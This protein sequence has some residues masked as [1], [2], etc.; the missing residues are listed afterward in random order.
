LERLRGG[1]ETATRVAKDLLDDPV[2]ERL[3]AE[4]SAE[5]VAEIRA[6]VEDRV[7]TGGT[8]RLFCDGGSHGNP[9]PSGAGGLVVDERD[10]ELDSYAV[11][12]G[13]GTNN[14]AEYRSL[15]EGLDR[16]LL[17]RPEKAE[18]LLDS[19]LLVRQ[20]QGAYKVKSPLLKPLYSEAV[21]RLAR[22]PQ[23]TIRHIP[24]DENAAAD[25]LAQSAIARARRK[26]AKGSGAAD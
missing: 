15:I 18:I 1:D 16:L 14:Q 20:L 19:E 22:L 3:A 12:L 21:R 24:R 8:L 10:R 26:R 2:W 5:A 9:G 7:R 13:E 23:Y 6:L 11:Y 25:R 4:H 17:L